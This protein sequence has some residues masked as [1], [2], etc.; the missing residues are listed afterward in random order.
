VEA[1][2]YQLYDWQRAALEPWRLFAQAANQL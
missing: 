2:L 1:M